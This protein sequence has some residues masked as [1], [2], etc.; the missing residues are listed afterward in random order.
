MVEEAEDGEITK[1][2]VE[3]IEEIEV[4]GKIAAKG[5]DGKIEEIEVD[6]KIAVREEVVIEDVVEE[7]VEDLEGLSMMLKLLEKWAMIQVMVLVT[8]Q[9]EVETEISKEET[10]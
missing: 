7:V 4:A 9:E 2:V 5:V 1:E 6:G 8:S 3:D 10:L